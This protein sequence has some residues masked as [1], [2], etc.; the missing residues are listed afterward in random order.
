MADVLDLAGHWK[1]RRM[2]LFDQF[3]CAS[4]SSTGYGS[5]YGDG[6]GYGSGSGYGRGDDNGKGEG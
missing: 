4:G 2:K 1:G 6:G 5:G 3:E